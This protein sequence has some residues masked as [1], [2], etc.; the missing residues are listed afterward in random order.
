MQGRSKRRAISA[1]I[2]A[3]LILAA[4]CTACTH[5]QTNPTGEVPSIAPGDPASAGAQRGVSYSLPMLQYDLKITRSLDSC[6]DNRPPVFTVKVEAQERYVAGER[7]E[8][9]YQA[10][11]SPFKTT[12][13]DISFHDSGTIHTIN[14]QARDQTGTVITN[15]VRTGLAIAAVATGNPLAAL[16]LVGATSG[17]IATVDESATAADSSSPQR[18]ELRCTAA[19]R[20]NL[21]ALAAATTNVKTLTRTVADL[22]DEV[23]RFSALAALRVLSVPDRRHLS[24]VARRLLTAERQLRAASA[25][26]TSLQNGLSATDERRWPDQAGGISA[27]SGPIVPSRASLEKLLGMIEVQQLRST[28]GRTRLV[29]LAASELGGVR[30][31]CHDDDEKNADE[32]VMERLSELT[33]LQFAL[34]A[35]VN[36]APLERYAGNAAVNSAI[37][38]HGDRRWGQGVFIREPVEARLV[39]CDGTATVSGLGCSG[40]RAPVYVG[41]PVIAPQLGRLRLLPFR[42]RPFENNHLQL[43]VRANGFIEQ[44]TYGEESSAAAATGTLADIA[45]RTQASLEAM[46]T[47]RRS[48]IQYARDTRTYQRNEAAANRAE[49]LAQLTHEVNVMKAERDRLTAQAAAPN[50]GAVG[51]AAA[52]KARIDAEVQLLLSQIARIRAANDLAALSPP[53]P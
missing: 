47:E 40:N 38:P 31:L 25:R 26:V 42:S 39:V 30:V 14:A 44:F 48:D 12:S 41:S 11:S 46:E 43:S 21:A 28:N 33:T 8:I 13:F 35:T 50:D 36:Q 52:D 17:K 7:F 32:C 20:E 27:H 23:T 2:L 45:E 29:S 16:P 22:T 3:G 51:Q 15:V 6:P 24:A 10:M 53:S 19:A 18:L 5:L 9:D 1:N 34:A 4:T 49:E 37:I